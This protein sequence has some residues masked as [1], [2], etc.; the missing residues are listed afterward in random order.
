MG[1]A[2]AIDYTLLIVSRFR[3]ELADGADRDE[4]LV[5]TM[6]TAGRTVLF[7][8]LTVSLSMATMALFPMYF[9]KSLAYAGVAVVALAAAGRRRGDTGRSSR[10]W[11]LGSTRWTCAGCGARLLGAPRTCAARR[12]TETFWYRWTKAGA[13]PVD[14]RRRGGHR[15]AADAGHTVPRGEMGISR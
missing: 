3:D 15:A 12:S 9:L 7:S 2:L 5:R 13:A 1:L 8:A 11:A 6:A 14:S 4:A 10:C